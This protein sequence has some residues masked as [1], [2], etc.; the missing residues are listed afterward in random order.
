MTMKKQTV[1][2]VTMLTLMVV[3]SAYY[4]VT[5][6][7]K[8]ADQV[9]TKAAED[10]QEMDINI[11]SVEQPAEL[12]KGEGSS[13]SDYFMN[14]Q[15][16]RTTLRQRMTEEYMK[17]ITDPEVSKEEL[18]QANQKMEQLMKIDKA[19][20]VLEEMIRQEGFHDAVVITGDP[21]VD[22]IIQSEKGLTKTQVVKLISL[23][24]QHLRVIP[25]QVSVAYRP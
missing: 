14:Y 2:L 1:W 24:K 9:V 4:I 7:V 13:A 17:V 11:R 23:A 16:Q 22:I 21:H 5:G 3:L 15:L 20:T 25:Q 12:A 6:P 10:A 19:E 8:T 18:A